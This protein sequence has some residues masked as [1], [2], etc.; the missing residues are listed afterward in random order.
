MPTDMTSAQKI[1]T[2]M[3]MTDEMVQYFLNHPSAYLELRDAAAKV[4]DK[5]RDQDADKVWLPLREWHDLTDNLE[6]RWGGMPNTYSHEVSVRR[7]SD[8]TES[9][10]SRRLTDQWVELL[11]GVW[12]KRS[13][14]PNNYKQGHEHFL[15]Y[16]EPLKE[17]DAA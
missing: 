17:V 10:Y 12:L 11:D 15:L 7:K 4:Y 16:R 1:V 6:V 9:H 14:W 2:R 13:N 5:R 8:S 3:G